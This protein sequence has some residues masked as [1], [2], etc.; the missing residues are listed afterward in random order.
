MVAGY[1]IGW[2]LVTFAVLYVLAGVFDDWKWGRED[3]DLV[4]KLRDAKAPD[5]VGDGTPRGAA[6]GDI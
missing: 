6:A 3:H 2:A 5:D 1:S 4:K